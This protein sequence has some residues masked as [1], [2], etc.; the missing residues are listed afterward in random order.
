MS[1]TPHQIRIY[2]NASLIL[3]EEIE[4][5]VLLEELNEL[6]ELIDLFCEGGNPRERNLLIKRKKIIKQYTPKIKE[7]KRVLTNTK[8][9]LKYNI[10]SSNTTV[11]H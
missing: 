1:F 9:R 5:K 8:K 11:S 6:T 7:C 4:Y 2:E 3:K 10:E